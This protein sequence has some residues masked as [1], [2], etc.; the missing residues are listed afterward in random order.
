MKSLYGYAKSK[1][2]T[3]T[4]NVSVF[5]LSEI[6]TAGQRYTPSLFSFFVTSNLPPPPQ[7]QTSSAANDTGWRIQK[8][9]KTSF[10]RNISFNKMADDIFLKLGSSFKI[11]NGRKTFAFVRFQR[12]LAASCTWYC[13]DLAKEVILEI[14]A[15]SSRTSMTTCFLSKSCCWNFKANELNNL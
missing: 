9:F 3:T 2:E 4:A 12:V 5:K 10:N 13:S 14:Y 11:L 7:Y 8:K 15:I 1:Y 6:L